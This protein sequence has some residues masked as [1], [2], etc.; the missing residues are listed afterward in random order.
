M[1]YLLLALL[2]S[3]VL[4]GC[5]QRQPTE[6]FDKPIFRVYSPI[7]DKADDY[8]EIMPHGD[9]E[10]ENIT[11]YY[12]NLDYIVFEMTHPD[13]DKWVI[14]LDKVEDDNEEDIISL[15]TN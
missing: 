7:E 12:E 2:I 3:I 1:K 6:V 14:T 11:K 5:E 9:W 4:V 8:F 10:M 13:G 15:P